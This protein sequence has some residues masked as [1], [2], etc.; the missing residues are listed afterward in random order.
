MNFKYSRNSITPPTHLDRFKRHIGVRQT[1]LEWYHR[2]HDALFLRRYLRY[3]SR[4]RWSLTPRCRACPPSCATRSLGSGGTTSRRRTHAVL[5]DERAPRPHARHTRDHRR[6]ARDV[7]TLLARRRDVV[8]PLPS[9]RV[10]Q[11]GG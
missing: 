5:N 11:L 9:G 6:E 1:Q 7:D 8:P 4:P 10:A 3:W 2:D